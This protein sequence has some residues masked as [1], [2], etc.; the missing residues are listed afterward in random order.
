MAKKLQD[1]GWQILEQRYRRPGLELDIVAHRLQTL[2]VVEVK[3]RTGVPAEIADLVPVKK[4]RALVRGAQ[5]FVSENA[6]TNVETIRFDLV[7]VIFN[8]LGH[9]EKIRRYQDVF[10]AQGHVE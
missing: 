3:A 5:R 9:V 7:L 8:T 2:C 10:D 6:P 4:Q 1:R